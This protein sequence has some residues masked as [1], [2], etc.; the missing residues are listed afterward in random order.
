[1]PSARE[2]N[3]LSASAEKFRLRHQP[4]TISKYFGNRIELR[5]G[6]RMAQVRAARR[7]DG[8]HRGAFFRNWLQ[9]PFNIAS[10]TPS[11]RM[12]AKRMAAGLGPGDTVIELGAGTGTLTEAIAASG[13]LD[14]DLYLIEQNAQFVEILKRRFPG[15]TVLRLDAADIHRSLA[16][17]AGRVDCVVS[18]LPILWF[19]GKKKLGILRAAFEMLQPRGYMRQ[20]TYFSRPPVRGGLLRE[21]G[22]TARLDAVAPLNLPPAFV[23]RL[24]RLGADGPLASAQTLRQHP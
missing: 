12:L 15:A 23:F 10:V 1:V 14:R 6:L 8:P 2:L 20:L 21:L 24:Q 11:G 19:D 3:H 9:D 5:K 16:S 17:L 22:L 4:V 18:G 13:V 7:A